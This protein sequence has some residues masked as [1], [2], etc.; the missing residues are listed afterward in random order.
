MAQFCETER[1]EILH[2]CDIIRIFRTLGVATNIH[3]SAAI[4]EYIGVRS[5]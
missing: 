2:V 5:S 1:A 4:Y 3:N